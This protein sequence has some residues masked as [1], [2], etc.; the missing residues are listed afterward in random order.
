MA[1]FILESGY[2]KTELAQKSNNCFGMKCCVSGNTWPG[3]VWDGES[4]C[5][6][7]TDEYNAD[8]SKFTIPEYFRSY[9]CIE[10]SI[11]DH[12]AYLLGA[13]NDD[14]LRYDGLKG[15][16]DYRKAAQIIKGGGYATAPDY[17]DA[18]CNIIEIWGLTKWGLPQEQPA[19]EPVEPSPEPAIPDPDP[20]VVILKRGD[21]N[22]IRAAVS[23]LHQAVKKFEGGDSNG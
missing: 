3:S 5:K 9:P 20:D 22:A 13:M 23:I 1:Q 6:I 4:K 14:S 16:T 17:V 11:A 8:G 21:W 7:L 15:C 12:S 2:A 10:D 18:L 19:S